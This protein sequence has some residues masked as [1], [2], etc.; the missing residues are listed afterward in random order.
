[1]AYIGRRDRL[2]TCCRK[3]C[4][5]ESRCG[6]QFNKKMFESYGTIR[7]NDEEGF[8]LTVEVN[9]DLSNYYRSLIPKCYRVN[10]PRWPAHVTVVRPEKEIPPRIRYWGDYEGERI[11]FMYD[12]YVFCGKGYYWLDVWCKRLET[13]RD[14]LG[15]SIVSKYTLPP[16]G[17]TKCFHCT[18]GNYEEDL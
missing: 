17:H 16:T 10:R 12:P 15:L 3:T 13:I 18:I 5:F 4:G 6:D 1:M 14:E 7:Y 8:R 11:K 2:K 9:Q